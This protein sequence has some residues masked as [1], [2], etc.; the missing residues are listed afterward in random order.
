MKITQEEVVKV[1]RLARLALSP[2]E[3]NRMTGQLDQILSYVAKLE[4]LDTRNVEPTTHPQ[5]VVNRFRDDEVRPSLDR[6]QALA[7]GPRTGD[8]TF[9]V[10][11]VI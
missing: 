3:V 6:E 7:N 2:E 8:E 10:P 9:V 1:A 5:G 11:R 4:E